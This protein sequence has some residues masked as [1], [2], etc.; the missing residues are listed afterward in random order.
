MRFVIPKIY[1]QTEHRIDRDKI[2]PDA[3]YVVEK[4]QKAGYSAY[5]VGGSI[6]D[7][8]LGHKPKDFDIST[9]AKPEEIRALFRSCLL[10][11]R[12]FR[13]AHVRFG[14][15]VIEV[16]TF[17]QGDI[18]DDSLIVSDNIWGNEVGDVVRRD[19]TINGLMYDPIKET[20]IDY[21]KGYEDTQKR[22][23]RSIGNSFI[24][25][26]QDPV[27]MIRLLKFRARFGLDVDQ[28]AVDALLEC[29]AEILKSAPAR[30]LEE[31]LR[32]LE[33]GASYPFIKLL[34]DHGVLTILLPSISKFLEGPNGNIIY[35]YLQEIDAV[36]LQ[37]GERKPHRAVLL[38]AIAFPIFQ[39]HLHILHDGRDKPMHLGEIFQEAVFMVRDIFAPFLSV[40][41]RV[42][43][44]LLSILTSQYR[45]TPLEKRNKMP[46]RMPRIPEFA[47]ALDFF[48]L[49]A[50]IE[51][52][53]QT[54]FTEWHN[55]WR[56]DQRRRGHS[57]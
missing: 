54:L 28:E 30:V 57:R 36:V 17:R 41:K 34:A 33:S 1:S 10:I 2:D 20:V 11:G 7:L 22:F 4:L 23:L 40:P 16:A 52:G 50:R 49:R 24:R 26:K 5:V 46:V 48:G 56:R 29:R 53:Y 21:V 9:S 3:R 55:L 25:F 12:R 37:R 14:K 35:S 8:L 19:F 27:R 31:I 39:E 45:F 43:I 42:S 47:L 13:L 44:T 32:M 18:E 6:R 51:P 15:K 38:A